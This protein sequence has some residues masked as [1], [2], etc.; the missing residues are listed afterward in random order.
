MKVYRTQFLNNGRYYYGT[1]KWTVDNS[2]ESKYSSSDQFPFKEISHND[3]QQNGC[4]WLSGDTV[5]PNE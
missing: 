5:F 1:P 3:Y 4:I 2:V